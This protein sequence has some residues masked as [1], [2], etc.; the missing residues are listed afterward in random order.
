[1]D[2]KEQLDELRAHYNRREFIEND[3]VQFPHRYTLLQDVEI[4]CFLIATISWGNRQSILNSGERLLALMGDSPFDYILS[5]GYKTLTNKNIHRTFF[6]SD[7][8]YYCKGL[9]SL[10]TEY[11]SLEKLFAESGDL[12]SGISN[13]REKIALANG[14][15]NSKHISNPLKNSACKRLHMALRWLVRRDGVVD[16]GLW[17]SIS[18]ASLS[19]PLDT[20]VARISRE[21]GLLT[22][23]SNDKKAVEELTNKLLDL[24]PID[25]ISYD[26]ALFGWGE[27][28][29]FL[30]E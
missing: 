10:Y 18:P 25:P 19:I 9:K 21:L 14:G 13:Y 27:N 4:V 15:V 26:F 24:D 8:A 29:K 11:N 2:V 20:H 30:K 3:P 17:R 5:E 23:K 22:R 16:L 28:R 1:M 6:E 7:L 12:W